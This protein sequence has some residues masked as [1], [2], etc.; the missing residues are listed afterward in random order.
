M[1]ANHPVYYFDDGHTAI[2]SQMPAPTGLDPSGESWTAAP[3]VGNAKNSSV[4]PW[5]EDI[6]PFDETWNITQKSIEREERDRAKNKKRQQ[7][8][9]LSLSK[10]ANIR[11]NSVDLSST[12]FTQSRTVINTDATTETLTQATAKTTKSKKMAWNL[13]TPV[14]FDMPTI[15][16]SIRSGEWIDAIKARSQ[17]PDLEPYEVA[18]PLNFQPDEIKRR[19]MLAKAFRH[20]QEHLI[21][22][23][24]ELHTALV[25]YGVVMRSAENVVAMFDQPFNITRSFGK[26]QIKVLNRMSDEE[27]KMNNGVFRKMQIELIRDIA[28]MRR[29]EAEMGYLKTHP[30]RSIPNMQ[31]TMMGDGR[32]ESNWRDDDGKFNL[33]GPIK[34]GESCLTPGLEVPHPAVLAFSKSATTTPAEK[35]DFES[36]WGNTSSVARQAGSEEVQNGEMEG[37]LID[38]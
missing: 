33:L 16:P 18:E 19:D 5:A 6:A 10:A 34:I 14:W 38:F 4:A 17:Q 27:V 24:K 3:A 22:Q 26:E 36:I 12:L 20:V 11:D 28:G 35:D 25:N 31:V 1:S 9:D 13:L 32:Q 2:G 7:I 21:P 29:K 30:G 15:D 23:H 8:A 37:D